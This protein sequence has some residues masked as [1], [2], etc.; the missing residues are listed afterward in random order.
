MK[1]RTNRHAKGFTLIEVLVVIAIMAALAAISWVAVNSINSKE[2]NNK[3]QTHIDTIAACL[4]E[5]KSNAPTPMLWGNGDEDSANAL[6]QMLNSD[7]DGDGSTDKGLTPFCKQLRYY[8]PTSGE[9]PE[10]ILYTSAGK[11]KYVILD[12]WDEPYY[13]RLG[14]GQKGPVTHKSSGKTKAG[15]TTGKQMEGKG[16]NVDFDIFSLGEDR[17]GDGKNNKGEN[18]DNISNIKFLK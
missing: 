15:K 7:F 1:L 2:A 18:K 16:I 3:A 10:G 13:Y 5:Y 11:N 4:N 12:P 17:K 6:Y 8:D 9:R 14:Y